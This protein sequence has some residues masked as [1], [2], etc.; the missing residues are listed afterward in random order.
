MSKDIYADDRF[1][2]LGKIAPHSHETEVA[3][4]G[5]IILDNDCMNT[6]SSRIKPTDFYLKR[7]Q[8][9]YEAMLELFEQGKPVDYVTLDNAL[10]SKHKSEEAYGGLDYLTDLPGRISYIPSI[11][12]YIEI[13]IKLSQRRKLIKMARK[14]IEVAYDSTRDN[15]VIINKINDYVSKF[16]TQSDSEIQTIHE[17]GNQYR[18]SQAEGSKPVISTGYRQLDG[19]TGGIERGTFALI[20]S[21]S[22]V[23]KTTFALN[24]AKIQVSRF[25]NPV[26]FI[27]IETRAEQLYKNILASEAEI[28]VTN[29]KMNIGYDIEGEMLN[30]AAKRIENSP[31]Y[32]DDSSEI[33]IQQI[34][35][36]I[37]KAK[38]E[39]NCH[40]VFIDYFQIITTD[41]DRIASRE[42]K[43]SKIS[44]NLKAIAKKY[45]IV[46]FLI[47]QLRDTEYKKGNVIPTPRPHD[48]RECKAVYHDCDLCMMLSRPSYFSGKEDNKVEII[49]NKQR[50][51]P[52]GVR[53]K[54][55]YFPDKMLFKE[56]E[57]K[58]VE[59]FQDKD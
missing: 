57:F 49:I 44:K 9:I 4:L 7:N 22:S 35:E 34:R 6:V 45:E 52:R 17:I 3:L 48:L 15:T 18:I 28:S 31:L 59:N 5:S 42:Q 21:W 39:Y 33:T 12:N 30:S 40:V 27:S 51:G 20:A 53:V 1:E 8:R 54:L 43:L 56:P 14:V 26:L 10:K 38:H 41:N 16:Y 36:K 23:G 2:E 32:I 37:H 46:L 11:S 47:V 29:I 13:I 25:D 24:L 58:D 19:Y 50:T 55:D